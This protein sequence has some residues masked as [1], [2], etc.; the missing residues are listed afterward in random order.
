MLGINTVFFYFCFF[1]GVL[2]SG[3]FW[4]RIFSYREFICILN[5]D[6]LNSF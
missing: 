6:F 4:G 3:F 1:I 5:L 2:F